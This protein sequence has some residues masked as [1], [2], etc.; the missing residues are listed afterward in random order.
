MIIRCDWAWAIMYL[1]WLL[2]I[3]CV[4]LLRL[5]AR[6][7]HACGQIVGTLVDSFCVLHIPPVNK[8]SET[9]RVLIQLATEGWGVAVLLS[10]A[11]LQVYN[12]DLRL[13]PWVLGVHHRKWPAGL[14]RYLWHRKCCSISGRYPVVSSIP[15]PTMRMYDNSHHQMLLLI[16]YKRTPH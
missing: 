1:S 16:K 9:K 3:H 5:W 11:A 12:P 7:G 15:R 8:R 6:C 10:R 4:I 14:P 2:N 13:S